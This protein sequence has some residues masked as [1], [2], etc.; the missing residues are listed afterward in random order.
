MINDRS[1]KNG[2][3]SV[4]R[5]RYG[6]QALHRPANGRLSILSKR[7]QM[8]TLNETVSEWLRLMSITTPK[9]PLPIERLSETDDAGRTTLKNRDEARSFGPD[10]PE[11]AIVV[12]N[13]A[14]D[15]RV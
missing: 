14:L 4:R 12:I 3:K 2:Q 1:L 10:W 11:A 7:S 8:E 9:T 15:S 6:R 5:C 13:Q